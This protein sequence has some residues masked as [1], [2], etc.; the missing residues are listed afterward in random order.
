VLLCVAGASEEGARAVDIAAAVG[1]AVPTAHHLLSTLV[2]EG[3][4]CKDPRRRYFLGPKTGVLADAY[5]RQEAVP[6]GLGV[7]VRDLA[8]ATGETAYLTAWSRE[9]IAVLAVVAGGRAV[10]VARLHT[11]YHEHGHARAPGKVLLAYAGADLRRAH[12]EANPLTAL[13]PRTI[14]DPAAFAAELARVRELGFAVE[15]EEFEPGV[16]C[17]SAPLVEDGRV[18][19]ALT[20]S[21]P[22]ERLR[23]RLDHLVGTVLDVARGACGAAQSDGERGSDGW[24]ASGS[25]AMSM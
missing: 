22:V 7:A 16:G 25:T 20:V 12:L 5:A 14:T 4:L 6:E 3:L 19:A 15:D 1:V 2:A 18:L 8:A 24:R 23:A 13:T 11:G 17:V 10:R 21:A 9:E